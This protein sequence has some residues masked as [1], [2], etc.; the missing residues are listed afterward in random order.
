[1]I[2]WKNKES[3]GV[4]WKGRAHNAVYKGIDLVWRKVTSL[5]NAWFHDQGWTHDSGWFHN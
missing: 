2:H 1:M 5:F 3:V 4:Y